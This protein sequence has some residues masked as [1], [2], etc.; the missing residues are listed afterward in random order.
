MKLR[1]PASLL[2]T[3]GAQ[4]GGTHTATEAAAEPRRLPLLLPT[5]LSPTRHNVDCVTAVAVF[6]QDSPKSSPEVYVCIVRQWRKCSHHTLRTSRTSRRANNPHLQPLSNRTLCTLH[7][8]ALHKPHVQPLRNCF[9]RRLC[10]RQSP[11]QSRW[12]I[13][14]C[15][16]HT[17]CYKLHTAHCN[18]HCTPCNAH[19]TLCIAHCTLSARTLA[20]YGVQ[21]AWHSVQCALHGV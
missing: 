20:L 12:C 18:A 5:A 11:K 4:A 2:A 21:C 1:F 6:L 17:V 19:C 13:A 10:R 16:L 9:Q 8:F 15:T 3:A 7:T 14:H